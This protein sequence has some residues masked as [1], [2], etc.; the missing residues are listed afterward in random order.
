MQ[1]ERFARINEADAAS[2]SEA[3]RRTSQLGFQSSVPTQEIL[4][5][6]KDGEIV[7]K[8]LHNMI[9]KLCLQLVPRPVSSTVS[10]SK[11][12]TVFASVA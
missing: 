1:L 4:I 8:G 11:V 12:P 7:G 9:R 3:E 6:P 10:G 5:L 2:S